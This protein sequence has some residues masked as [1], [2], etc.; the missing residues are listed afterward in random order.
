[1]APPPQAAARR[2]VQR[3]GIALDLAEGAE[4]AGEAIGDSSPE[5]KLAEPLRG[6][7]SK[8]E[9][10]GKDGNLTIGELKVVGHKVD[11]MIF[12]SDVTEDTLKALKEL[13]FVQT[14]ESKAIKLLIGTIDVRK[15]DDLAKLDAVI[16][17]KPVKS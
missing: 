7:A 11:V 10:D 9:T 16:R 14:G 6:L 8:V 13:G 5:M 17:V 15:L 3:A 1:M 4:E 2:E 12:L